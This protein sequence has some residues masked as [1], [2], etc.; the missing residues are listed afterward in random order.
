MN[1]T[2]EYL[3]EVLNYRKFEG[4]VSRLAKSIKK[5]C[6][7]AEAIAFRGNSGALVGMA[8]CAK[9]RL[10][11]LLIRKGSS[12]SNTKI[13]GARG[14]HRI[15]IVDD[16]I[17]T[18]KTVKTIIRESKALMSEIECLGVFTY[19]QTNHKTVVR[20]GITIPVYRTGPK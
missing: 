1:V 16:F 5:H 4:I 6:P 19:D 20:S 18:G 14:I 7:R 2:T 15:V 9:V 12:H 10:P 17:S 8:V 11:P 3:D 13:E